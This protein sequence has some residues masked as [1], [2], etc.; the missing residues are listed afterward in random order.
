M[1]IDNDENDFIIKTTDK[2]DFKNYMK[3]RREE[4]DFEIYIKFRFKK[5][6]VYQ[7]NLFKNLIINKE[8]NLDDFEIKI[9]NIYFYCRKLGVEN[10]KV[11]ISFKIFEEK[12]I[13]IFYV[14]FLSNSQNGKIRDEFYVYD[15]LKDLI[16]EK[17]FILYELQKEKTNNILKQYPKLDQRNFNIIKKRKSPK[18]QLIKYTDYYNQFGDILFV[19]QTSCYPV[20][21]N[22]AVGG[23][24]GSGKSSLIN[25]ILG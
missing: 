19:E 6:D 8:K 3:L 23:F 16:I 24:I 4:I 2:I 18:F 21:I 9:N 1:F 22:I 5:N 20:K 10:T 25:T 7:I 17:K 11:D 15:K 13:D 14:S 12:S